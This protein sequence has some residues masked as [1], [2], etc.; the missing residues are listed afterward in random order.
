MSKVKRKNEFLM[1]FIRENYITS[2]R[3]SFRLKD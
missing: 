2:A 1:V 3:G